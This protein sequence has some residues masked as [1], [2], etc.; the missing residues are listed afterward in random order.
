[1]KNNYISNFGVV[2]V[3]WYKSVF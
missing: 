1:M 2:L 3:H